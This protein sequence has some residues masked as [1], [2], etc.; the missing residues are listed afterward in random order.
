MQFTGWLDFVDQL[1]P[2]IP[3]QE[4]TD[5]KIVHPLQQ[6]LPNLESHQLNLQLGVIILDI[7]NNPSYFD[8]AKSNEL[9]T[10]LQNLEFL[11]NNDTE[12]AP[13]TAVRKLFEK[14][15]SYL[16][17]GESWQFAKVGLEVNP[18]AQRVA[19]KLHTLQ[20][21]LEPFAGVAARKYEDQLADIFT[22]EILER[23]SQF[24]L[25]ANALG[26]YRGSVRWTD[27]LEGGENPT[28]HGWIQEL[29]KIGNRQEIPE[30]LLNI[31]ASESKA[32]PGVIIQLLEKNTF[33]S[34]G[35][36]PPL[37]LTDVEDPHKHENKVEL[38]L[39]LMGAGVLKVK[40]AGE[41][42]MH[43]FTP[44]PN[45][46]G[47]LDLSTLGAKMVNGIPV[48]VYQGKEYTPEDH[49]INVPLGDGKV[50]QWIIVKPGDVH[51]YQNVGISPA[52]TFALTLGFPKEAGLSLENDFYSSPL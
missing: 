49:F 1:G 17:K 13:Q 24:R 6:K 38:Y 2:Q 51:D 4:L 5:K 16:P 14:Q 43:S 41:E 28:L 8:P 12:T 15:N 7:L 9:L 47:Q 20:E 35:K 26:P 40:F 27:F 42:K 19:Y 34:T 37:R 30:I 18:Q 33:R 31:N 50:M 22:R 39:P 46:P 52:S 25:L 10:N 32:T 44:N 23:S 21:L 11:D 36:I 3:L 45:M 29:T 48:L